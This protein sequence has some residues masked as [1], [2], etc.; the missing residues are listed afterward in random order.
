MAVHKLPF[1]PEVEEAIG[2]GIG[3]ILEGAAGEPVLF[4]LLI[5]ASVPPGKWTA[6]DQLEQSCITNASNLRTLDMLTEAL[7]AEKKAAD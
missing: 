6:G 3:G 5:Q 7:K 1:S 4:V 2:Q